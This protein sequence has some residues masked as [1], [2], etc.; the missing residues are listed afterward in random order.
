MKTLFS[1]LILMSL[2]FLNAQHWVMD[3]KIDKYPIRMELVE[4]TEDDS[5]TISGYY[6]YTQYET[7]IFVYQNKRNGDELELAFYNPEGDEK[8]IFNGKFANGSYKGVWSKGNK[9]LNFEL[10][11]AASGSYTELVHL[12]NSKVVQIENAENQEIEGSY[13]FDWFLPKDQKIQTQFIQA[14]NLT[15]YRNF[16]SYTRETLDDFEKSYK[17]EVLPL[18]EADLESGE[19][20]GGFYNYSFSHSVTPLINTD[21]YL[22]LNYSGYQYTGGAHGISFASYFNYDRKA[23]RFL[24]IEDVLNLK[25]AREIN[26]V[27]D[28][29]VRRLYHIPKGAP[30]SSGDESPFITDEI[31]YSDNFYLTKE[32]II[33]HYGLYEMTP[34][35]HGYFELSISYEQLK[36]YLNP[37]FKY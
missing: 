16:D 18:I 7:P 37:G 10:K 24:K 4:S 32:G 31:E 1:L 5:Q 14:L 22:I 30:L 34:Y 36:P 28:K 9:K 35:A 19:L 3:G 11:P 20:Y 17:E 23:Q 6:W 25:Y 33:F 12:K 2:S 27:L 26:S 15:N 21:K 8:E 29:E 13:S